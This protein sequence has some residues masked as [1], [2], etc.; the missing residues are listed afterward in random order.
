MPGFASMIRF[1][2]GRSRFQAHEKFVESE[3]KKS[4]KKR[5]K[6]AELFL[7]QAKTEE[8]RRFHQ[9]RIDQLKVELA[10]A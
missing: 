2:E 3:K 1:C 9:G 5:L 4:L 8:D 6:N 7:N 10:T